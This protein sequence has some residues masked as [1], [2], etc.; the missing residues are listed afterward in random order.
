MN[1][2]MFLVSFG[3]LVASPAFAQQA[4]T[5]PKDIVARLYAIVAGKDGAYDGYAFTDK[6]VRAKYFS[7]SFRK[8]VE[9]ADKSAAGAEWFDTDPIMC[10]QAPEKPKTLDI[11]VESAGD[12]KS[13]VVARFAQRKQK[14]EVR[15]DFVRES[16]AWKI[17]DIRGEADGSN[18]Y[19]MRKLAAQ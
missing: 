19:S 1:R 3:S 4:P 16:G 14:I 8:A 12:E 18:M 7:A 6:A 11:S 9:R 2:R 17:D 15:Y 13:V 5:E 10:T